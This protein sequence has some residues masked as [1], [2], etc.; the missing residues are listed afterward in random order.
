M[1]DIIFGNYKTF[2]DLKLWLGGYTIG[3]PPVKEQRIDL[4]GADGSYELTEAFQ[5]MIFYDNRS[6]E[7]NFSIVAPREEWTDIEANVRHKLHGQKLTMQIPDDSLYEYT[8]RFSVGA[9]TKE[10]QLATIS[11]I[12]T[13]HPYKMK[14]KLTVVEK[15]LGTSPLEFELI[16]G[17]KKVVPKITITSGTVKITIDNSRSVSLIAGTHNRTNLFL[18]TG[19]NLVKFEGTANTKIIMEYQEGEL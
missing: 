12:G 3:E 6:F 9:L 17:R 11:I 15:T 18:N 16:N 4:P 1:K 5:G 14:R 10:G 7:A 8:G 2:T 19:K 13:L